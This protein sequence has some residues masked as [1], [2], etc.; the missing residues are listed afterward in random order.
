M[1]WIRSEDTLLRHPKTA[2]LQVL[3]KADVDVVIGRLHRLWWWCLDYAIDGDLSKREGKVIEQ[4]CGIPLQ[5]LIRAGF[6]DSRPYR[7]IHG[8]WDNQGQYLRSRYHKQPEIWQ[9]IEKLYKDDLDTSLDM[10]KPHPRI[11]PNERTDVQ[12]VRTYVTDVRTDV[13]VKKLGVAPL[14]PGGAVSLPE[15]ERMTPVEMESIRLK[16]LG[17]RPKKRGG[18]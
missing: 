6:V 4:A 10:S 18:L 5:T 16:N 11:S 12:D 3:L 2:H 15:E 8:W 7:R 1:A 14:A 9:R 13:D 17:P